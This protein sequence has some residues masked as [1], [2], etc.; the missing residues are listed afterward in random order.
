MDPVGQYSS[1]VDRTQ[2][3]VQRAEND[4]KAGALSAIYIVSHMLAA[5]FTLA[6]MLYVAGL[7][8]AVFNV[9]NAYVTWGW[10]RLWGP[11]IFL[12]GVPAGMIYFAYQERKSTQSMGAS[13]MGRL[14][15]RVIFGMWSLYLVVMGVF[16]AVCA[17]WQSIEDVGNCAASDLCMGV[18]MDA[19]KTSRALIM[20][21]VGIYVMLAIMI[22]ALLLAIYI[23][24]SSRDVHAANNNQYAQLVN[25]PQQFANARIGS[26]L[27]AGLPRPVGHLRAN[28]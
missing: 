17:L 27:E 16:G 25:Q 24:N 21:Q 2:Q 1:G 14:P 19:S 11:P 22:V 5:V 28:F 15:A 3:L 23:H 12:A 13:F 6:W 4:I 10:W 8:N 20:L 9:A 7:G 26:Q 18:A